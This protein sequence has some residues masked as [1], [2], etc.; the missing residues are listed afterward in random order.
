MKR[1]RLLNFDDVHT[2]IARKLGKSARDVWLIPVAGDKPFLSCG[3]AAGALFVG[4]Y[5][6]VIEPDDLLD[7][8][9]AVQVA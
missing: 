6:N 8:V 2:F 4:T 5:T 7:D 9:R 1:K 3:R